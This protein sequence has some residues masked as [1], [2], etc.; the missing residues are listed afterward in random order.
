MRW[1]ALPF[2]LLAFPTSAFAAAD[3][4][5]VWSFNGGQVAVQAQEDGSFSGT[6]IR[7]TRFAECV[8]PS[9][10]LM[11][12]GVRLQPDGSYWG[13]HQFFRRETCESTGRGQAAYRVM[14]RE[15]GERFLR[16]CF[17]PPETP[18]VQPTI[19]PDGSSANATSGCSDSDLVSELPS[20]TPKVQE[21]AKLPSNKRCRSRRAFTIR[22]KEPQGDALRSAKVFVNGKRA[23][24]RKG[25]RVTAK[26]DLRGLPRGRY[27]VRIAARTVLGRTI[28]GKRRYRTCA[29][30]HGPSNRGPL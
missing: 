14:L 19:A 20:G 9:G 3:I 12:A 25:E 17:A 30:K 4:E 21:I 26:V 29:G 22:L 6:V 23:A 7:P 24:V 18:D 8:H 13:G 28:K 27:T 15:G 5:A 16:V 11:W 1:L 2:L 10:E